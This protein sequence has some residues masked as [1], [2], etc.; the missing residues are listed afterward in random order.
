MCV[1][2]CVRVPVAVKQG[3]QQM[4]NRI[5]EEAEHAANQAQG[6][7]RYIDMHDVTSTYTC[8]LAATA[9]HAHIDI[10]HACAC[11]MM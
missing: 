9:C 2:I 5:S 3:A 11:V 4:G 1:S 6:Q 7:S 8:F 10:I